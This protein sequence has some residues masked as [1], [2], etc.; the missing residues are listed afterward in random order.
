MLLS[1]IIPT[2]QPGAYIW[3]C[4]DSLYRQTLSRCVFEVVFVLNGPREPYLSQLQQ[5][6]AERYE[7]LAC[8]VLYT[9][10][11]GVS[12][13]RNIALEACRGEY[14][15]FIDDDDWVSPAYLATLLSAASHDTVV[16]SDVLDYDEAT[17]QLKDDYL[18]KAFRTLGTG[19]RVSLFKGRS[20]LSSSCCKIIPRKMIGQRRFNTSFA[21]GEDAL[22]MATISNR[23][24]A[25]TL[26]A[27]DAIYYRRLRPLSASRRKRTRWQ[28]FR[29]SLRLS[30]NYMRLGLS[31]IRHYSHPLLASRI[32]AVMMWVVKG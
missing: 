27:P 22:F 10:E 23:M 25:I 15:C 4:L 8:Q 14:V 9:K 18:T 20:F 21:I 26:S 16:V 29:N 1:V 5:G 19:R 24:E 6:L 3:E 7:G 31:D 11:K 28:I 17:S 32:A 30:L 13:A 12:N 2:Y